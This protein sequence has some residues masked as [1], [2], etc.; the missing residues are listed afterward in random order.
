MVSNGGGRI[1]NIASQL[2]IKGGANMAHYVAAKAGVIGMGKA[3]ALELAPFGIT[4]NSIGSSPVGWC[5][6]GS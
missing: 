1:I 3:L 2:G 5:S 4:V 6:F